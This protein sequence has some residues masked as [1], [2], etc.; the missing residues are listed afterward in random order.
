[1]SVGISPAQGS[2]A[3]RYQVLQAP[4]VHNA[5]AGDRGDAD[6][7]LRRISA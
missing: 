4:P 1:M 6:M 2:K 7:S 5:V 3:N